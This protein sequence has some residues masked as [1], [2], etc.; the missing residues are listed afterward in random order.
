MQTLII[1]T[2]RI[3]GV[4]LLKFHYISMC[5]DESF[6]AFYQDVLKESEARIDVF[7][8]YWIKFFSNN[9]NKSVM[10]ESLAWQ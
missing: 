2:G 9:M 10:L 4:N 1:A 3:K 5:T 6:S 7:Y 8:L